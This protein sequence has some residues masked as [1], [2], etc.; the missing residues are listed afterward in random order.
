MSLPTPIPNLAIDWESIESIRASLKTELSQSPLPSSP[1][2]SPSPSS[3]HSSMSASFEEFCKSECSNKLMKSNTLS[4]TCSFCKNASIMLDDGHY[5]CQF[6]QSIVDRNIDHGAEW[7]YYGCEDNKHSD[8]TRCGLPTSDLLPDS[9]LGS[10]IGFTYNESYDVR[11]MRKYHL[12]NSMTYKE[13]SLYNIFDILTIN[14]VNNGI[15]KSIIDEAKMLYKKVSETRISRGDNRNGLI[16]SSIYMSCKNNKVPRSAKE[17]AKIFNLDVT[18][19]TRG[20]KMYQELMKIN[21]ETT[22]ADDF[23]NRFCSK[24]NIDST[25]RDVCKFVVQRVVELSIVSEN[26]PPSVAAG[27]IYMCNI[28]YGWDLC[29]KTLSDACDISQVTVNK[30]YKKLIVYKSL[31][32]PP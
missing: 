29:K 11:I 3:T 31:L 22:T 32:I 16:A 1:S 14:A 27:I 10:M 13:R 5:V 9:S 4:N 20:C 18:T 2:P 21:V 17:I 12:W 23:I 7:R 25:K 6:C 26:T 30:C 19:M 8:P 15:S 24:L 28:I